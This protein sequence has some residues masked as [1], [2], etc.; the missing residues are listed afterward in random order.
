MEKRADIECRSSFFPFCL[1]LLKGLLSDSSSAN[2]FARQRAVCR[3]YWQLSSSHM[4]HSSGKL[5]TLGAFVKP[6][7]VFH[8]VSFLRKWV[9]VYTGALQSEKE[10]ILSKERKGAMKDYIWRQQLMISACYKRV[11]EWR[12]YEKRKKK[13]KRCHLAAL[14]FLWFVLLA[15][16]LAEPR[17]D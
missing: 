17:E 13:E 2:G 8:Y 5:D 3:L 16:V 1:D 6:K 7:V 9:S 10:T 4:E 12:G 14:A 11:G 15:V